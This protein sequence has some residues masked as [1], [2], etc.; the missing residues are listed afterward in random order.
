MIFS[1]SG[2]TVETAFIKTFLIVIAIIA[3]CWSVYRSKKLAEEVRNKELRIVELET[4]L[5]LERKDPWKVSIANIREVLNEW[6][7]RDIE[8]AAIVCGSDQYEQLINIFIDNGRY[9]QY[10]PRTHQVMFDGLIPVKR[11]PDIIGWYVRVK[12]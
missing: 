4:Q 2:V 7:K 8:P 12:R 3:V 9:I 6:F 11:D 5:D 10:H 1:A